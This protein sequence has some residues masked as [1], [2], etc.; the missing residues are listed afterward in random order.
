[1]GLKQDIYKAFEK[2]LTP[3]NVPDNFEFSSEGKDKINVLAE[4]LTNAILDY[5]TDR[6]VFRVDKLSAPVVQYNTKVTATAT[7]PINGLP[8]PPT[9]GGPVVIPPQ[10]IIFDLIGMDD[11][12]AV[13]NTTADVSVDNQ[14]ANGAI[15]DAQTNSNK[16]EVKLRKKEVKGESDKYK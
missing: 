16:S 3:S 5:L 12:A 8:I 1:M 15:G 4:D 6:A 9:T 13:T 11:R 2:N 14:P 10:P 7:A